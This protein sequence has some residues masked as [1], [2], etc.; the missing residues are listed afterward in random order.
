MEGVGFDS[1]GVNR[2]RQTM[3][4]VEERPV[5]VFG[6]LRIAII[7]IC[8]L[9]QG[10]ITHFRASILKRSRLSRARLGTGLP[11]T[12]ASASCASS[13]AIAMMSSA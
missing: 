13:S 8:V 12:S 1:V 9:A 3:E 10:E 11:F 5:I 2:T 6:N 7:E 4:M